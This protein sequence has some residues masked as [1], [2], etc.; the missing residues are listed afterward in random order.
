MEVEFL[1]NMRYGLLASKEE[2]EEWLSKLASFWEYCERAQRPPA[3]PLVIPSP[4]H[5]Y[6][7]SSPLPSPTGI[8]QLAPSAQQTTQQAHTYSPTSNMMYGIGNPTWHPSYQPGNAASPLALKP[9]LQNFRK[10]SLAEDDPTEPPAKRTNRQQPQSQL[11]S[12]SQ[13]PMHEIGYASSD[14][15]GRRP[16]H[17]STATSD[18]PRLPIPSLTLNTGAQNIQAATTQA[19]AGQYVSH[20]ASSAL[21]LPPLVPGMR[22]MSTVFAPTTTIFAPQLPTLASSGPHIPPISGSSMTPTTSYP[23]SNYGTPTKRLSP[24]NSFNHGAAS[25]A[26]S[27]LTDSFPHH[28]MTPMG[29]VTSTSGVH[30]PISNSPSVYLQQRPSP[31]K[32]VR[33]VN[34]LLYPPPSA[35]LHEYHISNAVTPGQMHYQPLGRRNEFRTGIVP[36]FAMARSNYYGPGQHQGVTTAAVLPMQHMAHG[37]VAL[38]TQSLRGN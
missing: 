35:F 28:S 13:M 16:L 30:T 32:P 17:I 21:S 18:L 6:N 36:E 38:P 34:T 15:Y 4:S 37:Q 14:D 25:Y 2:W 9:A 19:A 22:A 26:S 10:R 29:T 12:Q 5:R 1:S 24:H 31:Y 20:Q 7:L 11:P 33:H 8:Q 23:P 27:P 3:S